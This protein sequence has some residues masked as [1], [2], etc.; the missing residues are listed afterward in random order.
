MTWRAAGLAALLL[1]ACTRVQPGAHTAVRHGYTIPKTLRVVS[2]NVPRTLNPILATQTVEASLARLT[3]DILVS[4]DANGNF[5]PRLAREVPTRANG[6]H[7][8]RRSHHHLSPA[9]AR[10]LAGRRAVHQPR[11]EVHLRR[12]HE[13]QQRRDL[14]P[15]LRQRP[16]RRYPRSADRRLPPAPPFRAVRRGRL[17]RERQSL[18]DPARAPAGEIFEPQQRAVQ[19]G[20]DRHWPVQ[21]R[22]LGARRP[23]RV[24]SQRR[25]IISAVRRSSASSGDWSPTRTPR[26]S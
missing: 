26:S 14:A 1:T 2:G 19:L 10:A 17:R 22:A 15:R 24:R 9:P 5:V 7:Q 16:T 20:A 12:D 3:T 4:A 6:G 21:I 11:R 18:R 13:P 8:R 25:T 23:H